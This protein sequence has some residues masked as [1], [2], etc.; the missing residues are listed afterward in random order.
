MARIGLIGTTRPSVARKYIVS[1][2]ANCS[3]RKKKRKTMDMTEMGEYA[4]EAMP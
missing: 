1:I 3:V 2:T 4:R